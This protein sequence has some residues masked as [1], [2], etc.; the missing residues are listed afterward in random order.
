MPNEPRAH[1]P[2]VP[3]TDWLGDIDIGTWSWDP[4]LGTVAWDDATHRIYGLAP[5]EFDGTFAA[6][7][8]LV[9]PEDRDEVTDVIRRVAEQ[10]G[11]YS[12]RHRVVT[13]AGVIRWIEGQGRIDS[14]DG[15]PVSGRGI[16][17]ALTD[18][19][20]F[21]REREELT[22]SEE[23]ARADSDAS[24]ERLRFL[25]DLTD[26]IFG[27][28]NTERVARQFAGMV[29]E[30]LATACIVDVALQDPVGHILTCVTGPDGRQSINQGTEPFAPAAAA[31][32]TLL[33]D[34]RRPVPEWVLATDTDEQRALLPAEG[35]RYVAAVALEAHGSRIGTVTALRT[36][37]AWSSDARALLEA[38]CRR[39]A[40]AFDR[41]QLHAD[42]ARFVSLFQAGAM[43]P[44]LAGVPGFDVATHYRPATDLVRLGGD[45]YDGFEL[46]DG[47]WVLT[48][49]DVCGKGIVAAGHA[50]LA[51]TALRSAAMATQSAS[52]TL[53]I[54]N[55]ALLVEDSRPML[56][57][58]VAIIDPDRDRASI[59]LANAGHPP[60]LLVRGLN[61]WEEATAPGMMLGVTSEARFSA[62][63]IALE[64]GQSLVLYTD[65][66]T[67][68]RFAGTFFG[69]DRLGETLA[70]GWPAS[71]GA[72]VNDV[73][74]AID[75]WGAGR[76]T[77]DRLLVVARFSGD[78]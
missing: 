11:D 68:S 32:L 41:A 74:A 59:E 4:E 8:A 67:E 75:T 36:D 14:H 48:A 24:R 26:A 53:S 21:D 76:P 6:Y 64:A 13:P 57:A 69:V 22:A 35:R 49:G 73:A 33:V 58:V 16:A 65:G 43:K 42:R 5:G 50:E 7:L 77:D 40:G 2:T 55:Q 30:R 71:A 61:E 9:H 15:R 62:S 34:G 52:D 51:R 46:P 45:F 56:T 23:L 78:S 63:D 54:V 44:V 29:T 19:L 70:R 25:I 28:M 60:V 47:R 17:Y 10:G 37:R 1:P 66:V 18:R 12:I 3:P 72:L 31:R 20:V 27:S 38:S 39:V